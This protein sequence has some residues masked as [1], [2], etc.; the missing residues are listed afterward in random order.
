M[1]NHALTSFLLS[2]LMLSCNNK[3]QYQGKWTNDFI[4]N[5]NSEDYP[6]TFFK[7]EEDSIK[8]N[9]GVFNHWHNYKLNIN[10]GQF[11]FNNYKIDVSKK[12]DT[13]ILNNYSHYVKDDTD[14]I[15]EAY[16]GIPILDLELPKLDRI[17]RL[18]IDHSFPS[19]YIYFG[20]RLDNGK[21]S[22]QLND[23]FAEVQD[24][25]PF[26]E[27]RNCH[28]SRDELLPYPIIYS[29]IDK[30]TP[31]TYVDQ[32]FCELTKANNLKIGL[33]DDIHLT[34]NDTM[35]L[36]Y[37]FDILSKTLLGVQYDRAYQNHLYE[38]DLPQSP[39]PPNVPFLD[40]DNS[41]QEYFFLIDNKI[42]YNQKVIDDEQFLETVRLLIENDAALFTLY[43]LKSEYQYFLKMNSIIDNTYANLR[44]I[45]AKSKF[46]K[47]LKLLNQ[48]EISEIR[49]QIPIKHIWNVSIPHY[50]ALLGNKNSGFGM[51]LEPIDSLLPEKHIN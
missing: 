51:S 15:Q 16:Y 22:L 2:L 8:F 44:G 1:K 12:H 43:D 49:D 30:A 21:Y 46:N 36:D 4:Y 28:S 18:N 3:E 38:N 11:L 42:Y 23:K 20:K 41:N 45:I 33:I 50:Q 9:Y 29:F 14:S 13:L 48:K 34:S 17:E 27:Y 31:L 47:Q 5:L 25:I 35:V 32:I 26:T 6:P 10:N 37:S 19:Y 39:P 7:I 40:F 24:L